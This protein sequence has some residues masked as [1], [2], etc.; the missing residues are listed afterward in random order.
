MGNSSCYDNENDQKTN[1]IINNNDD[2][3][4]FKEIPKIH[5]KP[6]GGSN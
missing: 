3:T 4:Q 2:G 6:G 1:E 5:K